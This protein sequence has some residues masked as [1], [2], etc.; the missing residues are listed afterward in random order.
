MRRPFALLLFAA[1]SLAAGRDPVLLPAGTTVPIRFLQK[2]RSGR[3]GVGTRVLV[4]TLGALVDDGCVVVSPYT[5]VV[6]RVTRSRAGHLFGGRG[7]LALRFDSLE[8]RPGEW[9][10][11]DAVLDALE[12]TRKTD[13]T[14][15]GIVYGSRASVASRAVPLGIAGAAGL[16]AGPLAV[17]GGYWLARRGPSARITPGQTGTLRFIAP[18]SV[19][20]ESLCRSGTAPR[21]PPGVPQPPAIPARRAGAGGESPRR[22]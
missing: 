16:D 5:R 2:I 22:P 10:A 4:Q 12:Y 15:S 17:L 8:V 7:V 11:I 13:L 9:L 14:D 1:G 19:A 20:G 3:D 21:P 6:G 18:L